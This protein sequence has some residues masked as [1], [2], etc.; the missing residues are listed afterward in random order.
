MITCSHRI[1]SPAANISTQTHRPLR[2]AG[3]GVHFVSKR[4]SRPGSSLTSCQQSHS[5]S[6]MAL[7]SSAVDV[8]QAGE[9]RG[10]NITMTGR[11]LQALKCNCCNSLSASYTNH[12]TQTNLC[13]H[14]QNQVEAP[15]LHLQHAQDA[16]RKQQQQDGAPLPLP[17]A[18]VCVCVCVCILH[19]V[20]HCWPLCSHTRRAEVSPEAVR[21]IADHLCACC[22]HWLRQ[23]CWQLY[24][25]WP[26]PWLPC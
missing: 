15:E 6:F 26:S 24:R 8:M 1:F 16:L 22:S 9:F 25:V 5:L 7:G 23:R 2:S 4:C 3:H 19:T 17:L 21:N 14:L 13:L 12:R 10:A 11:Q 20:V 18:K